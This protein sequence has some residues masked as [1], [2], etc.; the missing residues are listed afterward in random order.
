MALNTELLENSF[1]LLRDQQEEF[2]QYFYQTLFADYPEVRP[3]FAHTDMVEQPKKLFK[4][5]T[6]T[7]ATTLSPSPSN[8]GISL[9]QESSLH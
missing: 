3:L 2:T 5:L 9:N 4:A 1:A 8:G 6:L 7:V